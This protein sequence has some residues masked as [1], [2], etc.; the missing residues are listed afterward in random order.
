M[1]I[2]DPSRGAPDRLQGA[3][4]RTNR[5]RVRERRPRGP[6]PG[7]GVEVTLPQGSQEDH[8]GGGHTGKAGGGVDTNE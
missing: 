6:V 4:R 1:A 3:V 2:S 8:H 7:S 5:L